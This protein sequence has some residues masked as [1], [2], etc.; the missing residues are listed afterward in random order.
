MGVR[1]VFLAVVLVW[2][3]LTGCAVQPVVGALPQGIWHDAA[4][5]Y[6]PQRVTE[7]ADAV[8]GLD[9]GMRQ[10]LLEQA[11][12]DPSVQGR[13]DTLIAALYGPAGIRLSYTSGHTTGAAQTWQSQSGDCLSLT[14]LAYAAAKSMGLSAHMQEVRVPLL[15]DRRDGVDYVNGHVNLYVRNDFEIV[16]DGRAMLPGGFV[17]DFEPQPGT[18]A[19]GRWLG[20]GA[21]LARYYNNRATEYLARDDRPNAYAYFRAALAMQ[22]DYAP[23]YVNLAQLYQRQGLGGDAE[24]LLLH[25]IALDPASYAAL[26][27]VQQLLASQGRHIEA[28]HYAERLAQRQSEDPYYWLGQGLDALQSGRNAAAIAALEKA[29]SLTTG[30][31]EIHTHLGVAYLRNGQTEAAAKQLATL[32]GINRRSPGAAVLAKKL[33]AVGRG[34]TLASAAR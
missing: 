34:A 17:I 21:I 24:Q 31:E 20:E 33:R 6:G 10:S 28:G 5:D 2:V 4:F 8:F 18:R 16:I 29:A 25:A 3:G 14:I 26:R 22:P 11:R 7:G 12:G 23:P 27:N 9:A 13:L 15:V 30:F 19:R 32:Q 1:R